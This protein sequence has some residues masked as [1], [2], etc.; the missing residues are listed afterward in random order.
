MATRVANLA[1]EVG[2]DIT[3]LTKG[4]RK[5]NGEVSKFSNNTVKATKL[6]A[7]AFKLAAGAALTLTS[8]LAVVAKSALST[9]ENLSDM[10]NKANVGVEKLQALRFAADQNGAS[11]RDMDD[12]LTRLTRRMSLFAVDGGGPAKLAIEELGIAVTDASGDLR[13]S[14][15]VFDEIISKFGEMENSSRKAA[16][17]S[18]LFGEDAGPRLVPLLNQGV[19]GMAALTEKA[20]DLGVVLDGVAVRD[21]AEAN[22]QFRALGD[23]LRG[24]VTK[25]V[26]E[27]SDTWLELADVLTKTVLPVAAGVAE[28]FANAAARIGDILSPL[29]GI[30]DWYNGLP[31]PLRKIIAGAAG[32]LADPAGSVVKKV[33]GVL[34]MGRQSGFG[35]G[36]LMPY[37]ETAPPGIGEGGQFTPPSNQAVDAP[38]TDGQIPSSP[39]FGQAPESGGPGM[40]FGS[41]LGLPENID[42][43]LGEA[44]TKTKEHQDR[45][46]DIARSGAASREQ[47]ADS[48]F[49]TVQDVT[50][51]GLSNLAALSNS[52]NKEL[53]NIGKAASIAQGL[54]SAREAIVTAY[55]AG[56]KLGGPPVGAA[57]AATAGAAQFA[58]L[59]AI[60]STSYGTS[61][62]GGS[63]SSGGGG[64][65]STA[66]T[67][68]SSTTTTG[69]AAQS[70]SVSGISADKFYSGEMVQ[71][72]L[73]K[74]SDAAGDRGMT[75]MVQS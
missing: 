19:A 38:E 64:Y 70:I 58:N 22:A 9:A 41:M 6:V 14:G 73:E 56:S 35:S 59:A 42:D 1:V 37:A 21:A 36:N 32:G 8:G 44:Q 65:T 43:L 68:S 16:L 33:K 55:A 63:A 52:G 13:T 62:G 29:A 47:I 28:A 45:L 53:F 74:L 12:A 3:P 48:E 61:G 30:N 23:G 40:T 54:L 46:T 31:E 15:D 50:K 25:Q 57:Y 24:Q 4:F 71:G 27:H 66:S 34:D 10:A 11:A 26:I 17:A 20:K 72:L 39:T 49:A 18:A 67:A 2:A 69:D 7:G 51:Q 5:A 60:K 75:L